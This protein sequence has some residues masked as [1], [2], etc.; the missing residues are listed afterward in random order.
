MLSKIN[1]RYKDSKKLAKEIN[2]ATYLLLWYF[3]S[4]YLVKNPA[5]I[6]PRPF[7]Q[8]N[9]GEKVDRV[10]IAKHH[11]GYLDRLGGSTQEFS[12]FIN[13]L[14]EEYNMKIEVESDNILVLTK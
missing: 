8:K 6:F 12:Q 4:P 7:N 3:L 9:L 5:W 2:K 10:I 11:H 1:Q 14:K 13:I